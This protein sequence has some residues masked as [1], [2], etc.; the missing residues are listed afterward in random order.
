MGNSNGG[1]DFPNSE[2]GWYEYMPTGHLQPWDLMI[3]PVLHQKL[4]LSHRFT[5]AVG[6]LLF[7]FKES[8][9]KAPHHSQRN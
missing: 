5:V 3:G 6:V 7:A 2:A 9:V 8:N 4:V 1:I